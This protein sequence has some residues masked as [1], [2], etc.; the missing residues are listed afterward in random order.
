[1]STF[2]CGFSIFH[3]P[4]CLLLASLLPN[5]LYGLHKYL[6]CRQDHCMVA[7]LLPGLRSEGVSPRFLEGVFGIWAAHHLPMCRPFRA[8]I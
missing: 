8:N 6:E 2:T 7:L 5:I 4:P 3:F 1:M